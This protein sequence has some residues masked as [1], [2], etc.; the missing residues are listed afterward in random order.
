MEKTAAL[1]CRQITWS[2]LAAPPEATYLQ[3]TGPRQQ[4]QTVL[5]RTSAAICYVHSFLWISFWYCCLHFNYRHDGI[6]PQKMQFPCRKGRLLVVP[7]KFS[8]SIQSHYSFCIKGEERL[9]LAASYCHV[10]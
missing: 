4:F 7:F 6:L 3:F 2:S 9:L 10:P 5:R 1:T 8:N